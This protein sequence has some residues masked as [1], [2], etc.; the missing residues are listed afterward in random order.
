LD[1]RFEELQLE[2]ASLEL[3]AQVAVAEQVGFSSLRMFEAAG[4]W[5]LQQ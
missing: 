5:L 2:A 3:A 4:C 1:L